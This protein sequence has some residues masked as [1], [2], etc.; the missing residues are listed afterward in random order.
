MPAER[1]SKRVYAA[2]DCSTVEHPRPKAGV[3][4]VMAGMALYQNLVADLRGEEFVEHIPQ[5]RLLALVGLGDGT[6]VASR[7]D[8]ALEGE[9]LY[10]LKDWIDRKWMWQYTGG[11]PSLDDEE[12]VTDAIA[13]RANALDVLRNTPMRCGGCGAKVG[14]N[15]L[16]RALSSLPDVPPSNRCVVE[17]GLD[18]PDDGAVV[19]YDDTRLVHTGLFAFY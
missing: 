12:E 7:G 2:G 6:C 1:H 3:F 8:L 13:S 16:T 11:L 14:S 18:A 17:V 19:A 10:R 4:A 9:W 5:T 15:T